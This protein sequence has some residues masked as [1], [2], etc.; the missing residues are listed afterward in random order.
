MTPEIF[1][2]KITLKNRVFKGYSVTKNSQ[3]FKGILMRRRVRCIVGR[4]LQ[5]ARLSRRE[6]AFS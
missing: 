3:L 4:N 6:T 2:G 1:A 5:F